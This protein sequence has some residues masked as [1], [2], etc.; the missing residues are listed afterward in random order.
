MLEAELYKRVDTVE[1]EQGDL[2]RRWQHCLA[3][4]IVRRMKAGGST[5]AD[6]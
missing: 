3:D 5:S 6:D 1:R 2:K 4:I